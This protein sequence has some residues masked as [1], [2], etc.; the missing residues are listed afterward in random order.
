MNPFFEKPS[1]VTPG[2]PMPLFVQKNA[3][4]MISPEASQM[5]LSPSL[6]PN[7][8]T[9]AP[10]QVEPQQRYRSPT[11]PRADVE[12]HEHSFGASPRPPQQDYQSPVP[13]RLDV[14]KEEVRF[15]A[16]ATARGRTPQRPAFPSHTSHVQST[17]A[18]K[19]QKRSRSPVK[20][21]LGFGKSTSL[22]D[23][24]NDPRS[25]SNSASP[26]KNKTPLKTWGNRIRHGFL[27]RI[28]FM[29]NALIDIDR[30]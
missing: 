13:R 26:E 27:V 11:P 3:N 12:E 6:I 14:T 17:D 1:P 29:P 2:F 5:P 8:Q 4:A 24:P 30:S 20:N 15:E 21:F 7:V 23:I 22:K 25:K 19:P 18:A 28:P 16:G 9:L 10:G